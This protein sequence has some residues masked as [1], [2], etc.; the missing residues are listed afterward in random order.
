MKKKFI[1]GVLA[2]VIGGFPLFVT[3]SAHAVTT[4]ISC[5]PLIYDNIMLPCSTEHYALVESQQPQSYS[6]M[7]S[8]NAQT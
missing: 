6:Q 8:Q 7:H 4:N 1:A 5:N 2:I 3:S